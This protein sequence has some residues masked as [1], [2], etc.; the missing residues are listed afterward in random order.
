MTEQIKC[1]EVNHV[2][3]INVLNLKEI[4]IS[5]GGTKRI[6]QT[7]YYVLRAIIHSYLIA[8]IKITIND[9][10]N[11]LCDRLMWTSDIILVTSMK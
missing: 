11:K 5:I 3:N 9:Y 6:Q 8:C 2:C 10:C 7:N 4:L 1:T